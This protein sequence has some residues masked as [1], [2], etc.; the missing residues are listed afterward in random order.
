MARWLLALARAGSMECGTHV[1]VMTL[2]VRGPA[3][4]FSRTRGSKGANGFFE[5]DFSTVF[6]IWPGLFI[7]YF[8]QKVRGNITAIGIE[9]D[10]MQ[11]HTG[12]L[13]QKAT[14]QLRPSW[15]KPCSHQP[16]ALLKTSPTDRSWTRVYGLA[17]IERCLRTHVNA[18]YSLFK[19][20]SAPPIVPPLCL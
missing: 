20:L 14:K 13:P 18:S 1:P 15:D 9:L 3:S 17:S 2:L 5:G 19:N 8:F 12:H 6:L 7:S 11:A 16:V 4:F 10:G